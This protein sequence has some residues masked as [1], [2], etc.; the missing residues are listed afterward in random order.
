MILTKLVLIKKCKKIEHSINEECFW[1]W[2]YFN[3]STISSGRNY[4]IS[5]M[6]NPDVIMAN[7]TEINAE[8]LNAHFPLVDGITNSFSH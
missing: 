7:I 3:F 2:K 4:A 6:S 8:S 1:A 5:S